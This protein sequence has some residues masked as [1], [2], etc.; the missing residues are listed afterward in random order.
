[1]CTKTSQHIPA[2]CSQ[3]WKPPEKPQTGEGVNTA[4]YSQ[5]TEHKLEIGFSDAHD[6]AD[7]PQKHVE[8]H[9]NAGRLAAA[10]GGVATPGSSAAAVV[11]A[12][13]RGPCQCP[14]TGGGSDGVRKTSALGK[15]PQGTQGPSVLFLTAHHSS[16]ITSKWKNKS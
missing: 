5:R 12:E 16:T 7:K 1:M 6:N 11:G 4:C 15:R 14:D 13:V 2:A 8:N 3:R 10:K 9:R